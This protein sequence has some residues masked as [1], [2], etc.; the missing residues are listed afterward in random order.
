MYFEV[1]KPLTAVAIAGT[2]CGD[3]W[4]EFSL[5]PMGLLGASDSIC[6]AMRRTD[7]GV[8]LT[9][10]VIDVCPQNPSMLIFPP[11]YQPEE[12]DF[13]PRSAALYYE[14]RKFTSCMF[15]RSSDPERCLGRELGLGLGRL[16]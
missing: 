1:L 8:T 14:V 15:R 16:C 13:K 10:F 11:S 4:R 3:V 9:L 12:S 2:F 6:A 5:V 7:T